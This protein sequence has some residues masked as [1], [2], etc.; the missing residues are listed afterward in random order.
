MHHNA[1]R[2]GLGKKIYEKD[3]LK[4]DLIKIAPEILKYSHP[5]WLKIDEFKSQ[6]KNIV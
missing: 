2:K 4:K 6:K 1:F 5:V 3:Q